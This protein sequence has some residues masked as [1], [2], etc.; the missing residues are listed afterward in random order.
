[1]RENASAKVAAW[2][3]GSPR[4][5]RRSAASGGCSGSAAPV[6]FTSRSPRRMNWVSA[7]FAQRLRRLVVAQPAQGAGLELTD[8]LPRDTERAA[9]LLERPGVCPVQPV[10]QDE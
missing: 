6:V 3:T 8:A 10:S 4:T 2:S 5:W 1:M 9:H 7:R